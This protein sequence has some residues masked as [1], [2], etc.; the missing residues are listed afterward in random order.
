MIDEFLSELDMCF[1]KDD[2]KAAVNCLEAWYKKAKDSKDLSLL[3]TV[4]NERMGFYRSV[5]NKELAMESVDRMLAL[6]DEYKLS[7]NKSIGTAYI[8]MGTVCARFK[9]YDRA[10]EYYKIAWDLVSENGTPYE[11]ASLENNRASTFEAAKDYKKALVS[12]DNALKILIDNNFDATYIAITYANKANCLINANAKKDAIETTIDK[13]ELILESEDIPYTPAYASACIKCA[14]L[15]YNMGN[16]G[17]ADE[18]TAR[19]NE[20]YA[21]GIL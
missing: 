20:I 21:G 19:A 18:L 11:M 1:A 2:D 9:D 13:M 14:S 10:S 3:V 12:Y 17:R 15:Y 7:S 4:L 8:N 5:G 16:K 6:I